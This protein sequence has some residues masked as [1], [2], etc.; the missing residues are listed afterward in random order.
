[1]STFK[2]TAFKTIILSVSTLSLFSFGLFGCATSSVNRQTAADCSSPAAQE[3]Q[4]CVD[5]AAQ[6]NAEWKLMRRNR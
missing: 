4:A 3:Q 2:T 1:M 5:R 6:Q